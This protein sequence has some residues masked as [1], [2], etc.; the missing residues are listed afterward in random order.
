M[1]PQL[2]GKGYRILCA[3]PGREALQA[4]QCGA[5]GP[6]GIV[7]GNE[8]AGISNE[9]LAIGDGTVSIPMCGNVESLNAAV[10]AAIFM[11]EF[12]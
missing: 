7:I 8:G 4:G 10:A 6:V 1:I 9:I 2:Q 3:V 12:R 11:Y 5:E